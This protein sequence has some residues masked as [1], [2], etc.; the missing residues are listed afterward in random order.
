[1]AQ[2]AVYSIAHRS[3]TRQTVRAAFREGANAI[4]CDIIYHDDGFY[5]QHDPFSEGT[6][7]S[8]FLQEIKKIADTEKE[9]FALIIFDLKETI[10]GPELRQVQGLVRSLFSDGMGIKVIYSVSSLERGSIFNGI[11]NELGPH[12][13]L[14]IDENDNPL[15]VQNFFEG[16][17]INRCCYGN[18]ITAALPEEFG[19]PVR[20][21]LRKA[22]LLKTRRQ[23]LKF[24]YIWTIDLKATMRAY[25]DLGVDGIVTNHVSGLKEVLQ[26][27]RYLRALRLA[28]R[29][30]MPLAGGVLPRYLINVRSKIIHDLNSERGGCHIGRIGADACLHAA[31]P[32]RK[33]GFRRCGKCHPF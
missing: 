1:M 4:E 13:G 24:V 23:I 30:D 32:S 11:L 10:G 29:S 14:S 2:K 7:L 26:E 15:R 20:E 25:L 6:A 16:I 28:T 3:N 5:A 18:G 8:L 33:I 12:E 19:G 9:R 22:V 31:S 17:G 21:S 27:E